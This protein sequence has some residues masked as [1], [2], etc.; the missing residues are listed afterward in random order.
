MTGD[1]F[2]LERFVTAQAGV[3][4]GVLAELRAGRKTGH[5]IWFVFPQLAGLGRSQTSRFYAIAS[6]EEA[7]AYLAHP[8][9]G[10]RLLACV[11]AV[12]GLPAAVGAV[13]I[14]G[15]LDARKVHSSMTLFGRAA[16]DEPR[17]SAML[18]RCYGGVTDEA[19]DALLGK[20]DR[21]SS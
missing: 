8:V 14:F 13:D 12:L 20:A 7:G 15:E 9:L 18:R 16:P 6:L 3:H 17:F 10:P 1:P 4:D 19:T 5:W 2:D 11:D 21:A